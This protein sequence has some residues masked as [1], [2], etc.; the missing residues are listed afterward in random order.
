MNSL[1]KIFLIALAV[2]VGI[3]F[4]IFQ[5]GEIRKKI[6]EEGFTVFPTEKVENILKDEN[7]KK[8][9]ILEIY[10]EKEEE[11]NEN[12]IRETEEINNK[13]NGAEKE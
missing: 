10:K 8:D 6:N 4:F 3:S 1:K 9:D 11:I 5:I 2:V 7:K 12:F 13:E